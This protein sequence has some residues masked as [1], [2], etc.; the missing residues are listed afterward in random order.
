MSVNEEGSKGE[1][2]F[3]AEVYAAQWGNTQGTIVLARPPAMWAYAATAGFTALA[4]I[5]FSVLGSYTR[6]ETVSGNV[7]SDLAVAKVYSP[8]EGT[9]AKRLV[10]E[11]QFVHE[12]QSLFIL[13]TETNRPSKTG[14]ESAIA[15]QLALRVDELK[16]ERLR[17]EEIFSQSYRALEEKIRTLGESVRQARD[18]ASLQGMK[19]QVDARNVGRLRQLAAEGFFPQTQMDEKEAELLDEK[20]K[21]AAYLRN[22]ADGAT[23]LATAH[24][25]FGKC[26]SRRE[27]SAFSAR[28]A[29]F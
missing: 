9:I 21:L 7:A 3:R 6:R 15:Q 4:L 1:E 26:A 12:G 29:D 13:S 8:V 23:E 5:L 25:D 20:A 22:A 11:G 24:S 2:L 14:A 10:A 27:K 16:G 17:R 28:S 18:A 19:V